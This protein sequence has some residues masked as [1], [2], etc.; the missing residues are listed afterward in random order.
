M[1]WIGFGS[2]IVCLIV[3]AFSVVQLERWIL[4]RKVWGSPFAVV[5]EPDTPIN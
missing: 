4:E 3:L 2:G 5:G 1:F